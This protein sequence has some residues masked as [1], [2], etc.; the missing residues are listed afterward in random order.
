MLEIVRTHEANL[1]LLNDAE[2]SAGAVAQ[3]ISYYMD[4][5][6]GSTLKF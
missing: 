1:R 3:V 4:R 6:A 5:N 2:Y